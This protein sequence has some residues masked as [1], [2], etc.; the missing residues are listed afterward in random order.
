MKLLSEGGQLPFPALLPSGLRAAAALDASCWP[1]CFRFHRLRVLDSPSILS[2]VF[3]KHSSK[4]VK[5]AFED[6]SFF[7]PKYFELLMNDCCLSFFEREAKRDWLCYLASLWLDLSGICAS[8][9]GLKDLFKSDM[10]YLHLL[11]TQSFCSSALLLQDLLLS[12]G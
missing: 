10:S 1:F 11:L 4:F 3:L 9:S 8:G 7:M 6:Y 5:D 2:S 12:F